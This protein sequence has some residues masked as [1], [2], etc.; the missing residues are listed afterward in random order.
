MEDINSCTRGTHE[1]PENWATTKSNDS[2][3][4]KYKR[5]F[6]YTCTESIQ[7]SFSIVPLFHLL[8]NVSMLIF[9]PFYYFVWMLLSL[10]MLTL[11]IITLSLSYKMY[12]NLLLRHFSVYSLGH[13]WL[14]TSS[15][16]S[17]GLVS[18]G[19][20]SP[21]SISIWWFPT[22]KFHLQ[23][24]CT[25]CVILICNKTKTWNKSDSQ[26]YLHLLS[27]IILYIFN[28]Y[29]SDEIHNYQVI[30]II[31]LHS[32]EKPYMYITIYNILNIL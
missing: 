7:N 18:C 29:I 9:V 16:S 20:L 11:T 1:F 24:N 30:H 4:G 19:L 32:G 6:F 3:V 2:T 17:R 28:M 21:G 12:V 13:V 14:Q 8:I 27:P 23:N 26:G 5:G 31:T 22:L 15:S 10:G 25:P